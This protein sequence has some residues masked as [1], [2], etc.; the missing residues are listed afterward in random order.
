MR[1]S[2]LKIMNFMET[3]RAVFTKEERLAPYRELGAALKI[4]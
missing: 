2:A 4:E 1:I 3:D